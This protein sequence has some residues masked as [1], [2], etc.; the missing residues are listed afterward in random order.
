MT[1]YIVGFEV[2]IAVT[3]KGMVWVVMACSLDIV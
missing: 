3:M 2:L 1:E